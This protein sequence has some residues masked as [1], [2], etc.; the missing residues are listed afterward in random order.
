[1]GETR[2]ETH[3]T[4]DDN[5]IKHVIIHALHSALFRVA[6]LTSPLLPHIHLSFAHSSRGAGV[7]PSLLWGAVNGRRAVN[8]GMLEGDGGAGGPLEPRDLGPAGEVLAKVDNPALRR[9]VAGGRAPAQR[10]RQLLHL[11][12]PGEREKGRKNMKN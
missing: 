6:S 5:H 11:P 12:R 2:F 10:H 9:G 8:L 7:S 4:R 3:Q 1:M